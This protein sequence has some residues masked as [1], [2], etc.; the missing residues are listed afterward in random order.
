MARFTRI[1]GEPVYSEIKPERCPLHNET[2]RDR[3]EQRRAFMEDIPTP[4]DLQADRLHRQTRGHKNG[5]R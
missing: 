4:E 5:N 1:D 3:A 2:D